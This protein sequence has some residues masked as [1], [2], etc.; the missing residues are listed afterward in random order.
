MAPQQQNQHNGDAEATSPHN[1]TNNIPE[2][3][4]EATYQDGLIHPAEP[5]DLPA[6]TPLSLHIVPRA[7]PADPAAEEPPAEAPE[8]AEQARP[9]ARMLLL[10]PLVGALLLGGAGH[11]ILI[12]ATDI[13]W[14]GIILYL[15]AVVLLAAGIVLRDRPHLLARFATHATSAP[16]SAPAVSKRDA[17]APAATSASPVVSPPVGLLGYPWRIAALVVVALLIAVHLYVL[18]LQPALPGYNWTFALWVGAIGL[19]LAVIVAAQRS[20]AAHTPAEQA[21]QTGWRQW[22]L[23][24][25]WVVLAVG[26]L[27]L[28][29]FG[30]RLWHLGTIPP[31][32]G[33]DEGSQGLEAMRVLRGD[34]SN[35]FTT[36]WLGVPTMSFYFNSL[37]IG[38]LGNTIFALRLPWVFIG[39]ATILVMFFLVNR[40][41]GLTMA[42]VT[43]ALFATYH[44]HIHFSR[45]GSNQVADTLF[46]ALA[47]LFLYRGYDQRKLLDWAL[48][49]VVIGAGQF[50]YAGA[51]FTAVV[52][53]AMLIFFT[54][55]DGLPFVRNRY[56]EVLVLAFAALVS[57]A[58][59]IQYAIR[60]PDDYN[61]RVNQVGI[62]QSGWL[63]NEQIVRESGPLPIL[64]DQGIRAGLAFNYYI[65]RNVW[66]GS[67]EPLMNFAA[68]ALFLLGLGYGILHMGNRRIFPMVAWWGGAIMMGGMLTE[69]PPSS[70]RLITTAAPAMFFLALALVRIGQMT[71]RALNVQRTQ[72][73]LVPYLAAAVLVLSAISIHWYFVEFT[74][75]H[76]YGGYNGMV[77]TAIGKQAHDEL[78]E[79]WRMYFFGPP[80]MYI[81]FGSIPYIA[82]E[83]EGEDIHQPLTEP[84]EPGF[85][86]TDKHAAFIFLPERRAEL[87]LLQQ[88]YPGG[89][90]EVVP[91]PVPDQEDPLYI[92]Y[93]VPREQLE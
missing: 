85:V 7:Q 47:L 32:L 26:A 74:P 72:R 42:L 13:T 27:V 8:E 37:S 14:L 79:D 55:R 87:E 90:V 92:L 31:N 75:M 71:L 59:M 33:G 63:E 60:F 4:I 52:V 43:T 5:L 38:P 77:A 81:G 36:G 50:F 78:D 45:L 49:G 35:P 46:V 17:P 22:L 24:H 68:A 70:Q 80:R 20:H 6:G 39:T 56:R 69:S 83:V 66:Y 58:P 76:R 12:Q 54:I 73:F 19:Y 10:L 34:I 29:G 41:S 86:R 30:L 11:Y 23:T 15:L 61:A 21:A 9:L 3:T 44:Y 57:S 18:Q 53:I 28:L 82:P 67:P 25:K 64:F 51:R 48:C 40:L 62:I 88:T 1:G 65:D 89:E 84:P 91:S 93:R 16:A 2:L